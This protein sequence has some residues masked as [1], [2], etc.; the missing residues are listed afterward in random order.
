[1]WF[2]I[3]IFSFY[4]YILAAILFI[5]E[6]MIASSFGLLNKGDYKERYKYDF[7]SYHKDDLHWFAFIV[8]LFTVNLSLIYLDKMFIFNYGHLYYNL[9]LQVNSH[10]LFHMQ[11]LLLINH[12]IQLIFKRNF[13]IYKKG[14]KIVNRNHKWVWI[15]HIISYSYAINTYFFTNKQS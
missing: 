10:P 12:F 7:L 14:F 1:V 4:G 9:D 15:I 6:N 2:V 8:I 13:F 5:A 11:I 3:E